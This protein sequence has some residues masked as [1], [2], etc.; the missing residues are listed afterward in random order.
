MEYVAAHRELWPKQ[1]ITKS[2]VQVTMKVN[3]APALVT[4]PA[5]ELMNLVAVEGGTAR[6][7]YQGALV[8]MPAVQTDL[9]AGAAAA[10]ARLYRGSTLPSA[11]S[12]NAPKAPNAPPAAAGESAAPRENPVVKFL[13]DSLVAFRSDSVIPQSSS[14]LAG[15]KFIALY[16][17][18]RS[19]PECAEFTPKLKNFYREHRIDSGKFEI[20]LVPTD[21]SAAETAYQ[22]REAEM[23]WLAVNY[24]RQEIIGGLRQQSVFRPDHRMPNHFGQ[25][26]H[27]ADLDSIVCG[28][29]ALQLLDP[30]QIDHSFRLADSILQ[31][32][33]AVEAAGE[34]ERVLVILFEQP[35]RSGHRGR[36][37][38]LKCRHHIW[39]DCHSA[40]RFKPTRCAPSADPAP[41]ARLLATSES[42][43]G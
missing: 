12:P 42:Y 16:F 25:R 4:V 31:P 30:A 1:V 17:A 10:Q 5:G 8:E 39:N 26:R 23:P 15:K 14:Q 6:L 40:L 13:G 19:S 21:R 36:L 27:C 24:S 3:G 37:I 32:I 7:V 29:N 38:Q 22:L 43:R 35:L 2:P 18:A 41:V 11:A 28:P 33:H 20:V 9:L 34:H